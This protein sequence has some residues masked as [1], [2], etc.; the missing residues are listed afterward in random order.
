MNRLSDSTLNRMTKKMLI[1]YVRMCEHNYDI[2]EETLQQQAENVKDWRPVKHGRWIPMDEYHAKCSVCGWC[3]KSNGKDDTGH[4][5]IHKVAYKYCT[6][7]GAEM[8]C[9]IDD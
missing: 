3:Q 6:A 2:A 8:D 1:E 7:C 9:D 4:A 5:Y